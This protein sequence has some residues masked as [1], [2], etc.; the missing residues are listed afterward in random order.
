VYVGN[1]V[2][3]WKLVFVF[4][5]NSLSLV[6]SCLRGCTFFFFYPVASKSLRVAGK[7]AVI[8][9]GIRQ[10]V[11]LSSSSCVPRVTVTVVTQCNTRAANNTAFVVTLV[12]FCD[13]LCHHMH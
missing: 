8:S 7:V 9:P 4:D 5:F 13:I 6:V 10:V 3:G 11:V 2:E 1:E 12:H